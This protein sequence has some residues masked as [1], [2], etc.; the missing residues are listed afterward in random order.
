MVNKINK[1][2]LIVSYILSFIF[3]CIVSY[4]NIRA[5]VILKNYCLNDFDCYVIFIIDEI[6]L[7]MREFFYI[8]L[9]GAIWYYSHIKLKELFDNRGSSDILDDNLN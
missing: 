1:I 5:I 3:F 4:Y 6:I 2:A 8:I 7:I 9:F